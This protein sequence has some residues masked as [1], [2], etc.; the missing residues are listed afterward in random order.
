M[1]IFTIGFTGKTAR[2][3]FSKL[4]AAGVK[5]VIDVRRSNQTQLAGFAKKNDLAFFLNELNHIAYEHRTELAPT[6]EMLKSYRQKE[7]D[8][9]AYERGFLKLISERKIEKNLDCC[10]FENSCLL[11][12]E[13][14]PH[15]CHRRLVA[16]YLQSKWGRIAIQHLV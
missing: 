9:A 14:Q 1:T 3:F 11:C 12:S 16:E 15:F 5:K 7:T 2:D 6:Q 8:W 4:K 13:H 10:S